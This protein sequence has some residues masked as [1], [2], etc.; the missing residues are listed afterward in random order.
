MPTYFL[1]QNASLIPIQSNSHF[2][3]RCK[4]AFYVYDS[5]LS[6]RNTSIGHAKRSDFTQ[7]L[8][9]SPGSTK[10]SI[11]SIFDE[12]KDRGKSFGVSRDKS[13]D[14]SYLIPQLHKNPGPAN[15]ENQK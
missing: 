7:P 2:I 3:V 15:Y 4:N 1:K 13:P 9:C 10:Y 11:K 14:R 5:Q 6:P 12:S 8:N